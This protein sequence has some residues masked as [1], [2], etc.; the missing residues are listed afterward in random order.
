MRSLRV[1]GHGV[2]LGESLRTRVE[3]RMA[4]TLSK[5][6]D[7]HMQVAAPATSPFAETGA[8]TAPIACCTSSPASPWRPWAPRTIR[9]RA[10][11]RPPTGWRPASGATSTA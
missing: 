2:D 4:A 5:Y 8:R 10:S 3:E 6:L 11:S 1:T 7:T 9:G